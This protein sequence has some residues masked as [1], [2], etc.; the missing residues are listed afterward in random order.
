MADHEQR[1]AQV[2]AGAGSSAAATPLSQDAST[3]EY[4]RIEWHGRPAVACVYPEPFA[5]A[6]H[7]YIDVTGLF[8]AGGLPVAEI[9]F[10]DEARGVIILEDLGDVVLREFLAEL[11]QPERE[12]YIDDAIRLIAKI[13]AA[14]PLAYE[15]GSIAGRLRFDTEKLQ[16]E[17]NF[18]LEHYFTTYKRQPPPET[19]A[20][21]L[22]LEFAS[23]AAE[24]DGR[25]SVLCHR[26]YHAAN[27]MVAPDRSLHII[28][29]QDARIGS[30]AYDLVSLL[31]DRVIEP[32]QD[33]WVAEKRSLLLRE[34]EALELDRIDPDVFAEEFRLQAIQRCLKAVGTFS[35]QSSV[36]GKT[37]FIP[38]IK[39]ML[40]ITLSAVRTAARFPVLEKALDRELTLKA[41]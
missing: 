1:L 36:R 20:E 17:L 22:R 40:E 30:A 8:E 16:W 26:D 34:R 37:Y 4:F 11:H 33:E 15:M 13:Q 32:P 23:L 7:N 25:A 38:Y 28:D 6:E 21:Q 5:A 35:Y 18:F 2:L 12:K 41:A 19:E 31:L 14:T 9:Y 10:V 27:L 39:P 24:L 29:H 3:R